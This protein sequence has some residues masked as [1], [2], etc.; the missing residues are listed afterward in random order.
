MFSVGGLNANILT[1]SGG[2]NYI[3]D[4]NDILI[5]P[6]VISAKN[7]IQ[8]RDTGSVYFNLKLTQKIKQLV[9]EIFNL[10]LEGNSI[11]MRWIK[12]DTAPHIDIGQDHFQNTYLMYLTNSPGE[13]RIENECYPIQKGIGYVFPENLSH[14]TR[15][16]GLEPRLLLGPMSEQGIP[17]GSYSGIYADGQTDIIYIKYFSGDGIKYKINNGSYD[18]VSFPILIHNTNTSFT[19]QVLFENDIFVFDSYTYF[20][21]DSDNIQFGSSSL[22]PSGSRP[23]ITVDGVVDY[24]GLVQN[25]NMFVNGFNNIYVYNLEIRSVNS[26]T[27]TVQSGWI[28]HSY[29]GMGASDNYI[30]NCA[31]DGDISSNSGGILGAYAGKGATSVYVKGCSSTGI[32]SANGGGIL[33]EHAG[34]NNGM[35]VCEGCWSSGNIDQNAGGIYGSSAG[36]SGGNVQA[37]HCY[38]Q[39]SQIST[40][41]GGIY[42]NLAG[43]SGSAQATDCYS[44][45]GIGTDGGGIFGK[46]SASDGGTTI[47]TNCYSSGIIITTGNGIYGSNSQPG[48]SQSNCYSANAVWSS[49]SANALLTGTPNLVVGTTWVET[50]TNSPYELFNIGYTPY[51][52]DNI[53]VS[54][55]V[56]AL[57]RSVSSNVEVGQSSSGAIVNDKSY[58]ILQKSGGDSGSYLSIS[59]NANTGVVSTTSSTV[60]GIY[61]LYIRNNGSYNI[62]VLYLTVNSPQVL[63]TNYPPANI[64]KFR[65]RPHPYYL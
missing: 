36:D 39:G 57:V 25:G 55:G 56:P 29:F 18:Y 2:L 13:F 63:G 62:T 5:L 33:G 4:I 22:N 24:P 11:P 65:I 15:M 10:Q 3:Q 45:G 52:A 27:L 21:C 1:T 43:T 17:V 20:I 38:S 53:T 59:I 28:G 8:N 35:L 30:V 42:G 58:T 12:G 16:T 14:E 61:T 23:V 54:G 32:I 48:A 6:E 19:L 51:T 49:A 46:A 31:S 40:N 41:A 34:Y 44:R 26:S 37:L 64:L 9:F 50:T 60:P 47:A 7:R